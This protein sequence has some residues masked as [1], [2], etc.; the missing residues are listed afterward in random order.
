MQ[1]KLILEIC[2]NHNGSS[3]LLKEMV[4]AASETG[5]KYVKIQD[6]NSKELTKRLR[7][8]SGKIK[9]RKLLVIKRPYMSELN[10]LKKLDMKR[11]FIS[12]FVDY[13][14]KYGLIPMVTPFTYNSFNRLKNQKVKAIKIASYDCSSVKFL[15]KFSKL[16]LPMIVSTGATKKSEILEAAK[17]L[18]SS[19]HAFLHCVTIYPTPLNKCNLNK[20]KFLRSVIKNVGWSDHTLFERDGHIASLAS[21]LCGANIIERHFTILKKDKTKDG[22]VSINFNE[23]KQLTSYMK[24]DKKNL[25]EVLNHLNKDWRISLGVGSTRLSHLELLNRDYYRGRFA[26]IMNG[27]VNYNWQKEIL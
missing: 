14:I 24:Q 9:N 5:A 26:K 19:L 20:I 15:E 16:K 2:Q 4:H 23:A 10:R 1:K 21:L 18:K 22:P 7:F 6:I 17:I 25:K 11:E 12:N 8:E 3:K 27:K 13:S